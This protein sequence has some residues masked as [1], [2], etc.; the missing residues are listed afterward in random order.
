MVR[1]FLDKTNPPSEQRLQSV[2]ADVFVFYT[3]ACELADAF[4]QDWAFSK[5]S[6]W[7]LKGV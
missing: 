6:G 5:S 7:M 1:P 2:L 3:R 4:S